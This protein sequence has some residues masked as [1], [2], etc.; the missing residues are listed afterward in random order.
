[1][2]EPTPR[3]AGGPRY[4]GEGDEYR[5]EDIELVTEA[6]P[7]RET[8]AA[9]RERILASAAREL[10]PTPAI[11]GRVRAALERW[12][13][14]AALA[15]AGLVLVVLGTG[16]TL[17]LAQA[18]AER[19]RMHAFLQMLNQPGRSWYMEGTDA[20]QGSGG[21]LVLPRSTGKAFVLFHDLRP[22]PAGSTYAL[23]LVSAEGSWV[24]GVNFGADGRDLQMVEVGM[25]L[26]GYERCA[27]TVEK[28][29]AGKKA[30]PV[31]MQ[32]RIV[33]P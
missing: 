6:L 13:R 29:A 7:V 27:V 19:D 11:A 9:L 33:A 1:M 31:V 10:A 23:W 24:R 26:T 4:P 30:G 32:S 25:E 16:T 17:Q 12:L 22:L 28:S 2:T 5:P 15:A 18:Q 21:T 20:W 14:P 3:F 8:P